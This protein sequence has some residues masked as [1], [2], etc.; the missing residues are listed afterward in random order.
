MGT[1]LQDLRYAVRKLLRTPGFTL[2]ALATLALAIGATTAVFSIVRGV[3]LDPLP[4]KNP[5]QLV[6]V[7]SVSEQGKPTLMSAPD[8]VDYRDQSSSFVGMA[9]IDQGSVNLTGPGVEPMRLVRAEVGARFFELLGVQPEIGRAFTP[10]EDAAG[11]PRV[12]ILSD[13]LWRSRFGA[14]PRVV[15]R[16]ISIDDSLYTV[17]GVA[18]ARFAYPALSDIW[19]PMVWPSWALEPSSRGMHYLTAIGR[20]KSGVSIEHARQE[21]A[22]I[23]R[24]LETQYPVSNTH[25]GGT[26]ELL[27]EQMVGDVRPALLAMLG[28]V[29]FVLLIACAN[30]ANLLLVRAATRESEIAVRVALGAGRGRIVRQLVTESVLLAAVGAALGAVLAMWVVQAVVAFGPA[31]VPRLGEV[32]VDGRA[33]LFTAIIAVVTGILFGLVP[34]LHAAR[35]SL[36]QLLRE[37][38]RGSSR[39]GAQRTRGALV[40]AEMALAVVLLTGAGLLLRSF[41]RLAQVDPG[42]RTDR[43]TSFSVTIP[44]TKYPHDR[45]KNAFVARL[46]EQ[47]ERLPGVEGVA[48]SSMRLLSGSGIRTLV[49]IAGRPEPAPG[50]E[51]VS[52]VDAVSP[53]YFRELGIPLKQGRLYTAAEDRSDARQVVVVNQELVRRYF[54]NENPIGQRI[55]LGVSHDT[56]QLGTEVESGGEIIGVVGDVKLLGLARENYPMTYV[57]YGALPL[58]DISV[59]VRSSADQKLIE[60]EIRAAVRAVD[61]ELP[62]YGLATADQIVSDSVAQPRFY[63]VLIGAFAAMALL[64]AALGIYGVISYTVSERTRE[65]GIRIAL[66]AS[67]E[68]VMR[69]VVGEGL[70]L[71]VVGVAMGLVAAVGLT[72]LIASLL[73]GVGAFDPLTFA[74]VAILLVGV[75]A[76]SSWLPARRA[77]RVDPVIAMRVE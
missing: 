28:A 3:L 65:L 50:N 58:N 22:T 41:I 15:G 62:V 77:A 44:D 9:A 33:L 49:K 55:T 14:D 34:A 66:G 23:G 76:V 7:G 40:I 11:A 16:S 48:V 36:D 72:R 42:F 59:V 70:W 26:I 25:R 51:A 63:L 4:F 12:V 32:A 54:P 17:V 21:I 53:G 61:P 46:S 38:R 29:G 37:G 5:A 20:V 57:P 45:Q 69:L 71:T 47:L 19:V 10:G 18:P 1:L 27:Q 39:G 56:A 52:A 68:R 30:V 35:S 6:S 67:S 74:G 24:R 13:A 60:S 8:F 64:L 43:V 2:V 31:R 73:F 75:A